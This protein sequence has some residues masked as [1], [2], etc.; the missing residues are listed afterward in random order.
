MIWCRRGGRAA[1]TQAAGRAALL[2]HRQT[3]PAWTTTQQMLDQGP[4][5]NQ[6]NKASVSPVTLLKAARPNSETAPLYGRQAANKPIQTGRPGAGLPK[7]PRTRFQAVATSLDTA[8]GGSSRRTRSQDVISHLRAERK[9][10]SCRSAA[11][12][13]HARLGPRGPRPGE[14]PDER[15][16][17]AGAIKITTADLKHQTNELNSS[18]WKRHQSSR[19]SSVTDKQTLRDELEPLPR[20]ERS[21]QSLVD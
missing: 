6:T 9:K 20:P 10:P 15:S 17:R 14:R 13:R 12:T 5:P 4:A 21:T 8:P 3:P 18:E 16:L 11:S 19:W 2:N 1:Q 7:E